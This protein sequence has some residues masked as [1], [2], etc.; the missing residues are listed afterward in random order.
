MEIRKN[1]LIMME[2]AVSGVTCL[3]VVNEGG[4]ESYR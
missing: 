1:S 2:K 4:R 3:I